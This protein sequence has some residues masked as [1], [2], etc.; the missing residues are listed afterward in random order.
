MEFQLFNTKPSAR[1]AAQPDSLELDFDRIKVVSHLVILAA[2]VFFGIAAI[3]GPSGGSE[4]GEVSWLVAVI[5]ISMPG[6]LVVRLLLDQRLERPILRLTQEGFIDRRQDRGWVS[7]PEVEEAS[8]KRQLLMRGIKIVLSD[9]SRA[10]V[11]MTFLQGT[12]RQVI[13]FIQQAARKAEARNREDADE[14]ETAD[15]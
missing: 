10:D 5:L 7:W 4:D 12:P 8:P 14:D 2:L 6:Y 9:G 13:E 15:R 1:G 11:D 3:V